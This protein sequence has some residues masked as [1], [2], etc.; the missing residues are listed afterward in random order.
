MTDKQ[1]DAAMQKA[2]IDMAIDG[3]KFSKLF[4]RVLTK[5]E[6]GETTRYVSQL[7]YFSERLQSNLDLAGIRLVNL[8]GHPFDSGVAASA[9]NIGDFAPDDELVVDQM[10]EPIIM[11][12]EG[13]LRSGTIMLRKVQS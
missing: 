4:S 1:K 8:E 5:L 12:P 6:A 7:Q 3:W 9:L 10:V 13:L 11:G 2:L